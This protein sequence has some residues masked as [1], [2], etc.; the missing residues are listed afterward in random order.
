M[1]QKE[2]E[3][4]EEEKEKE[5]GLRYTKRYIGERGESAKWW[6]YFG[7]LFQRGLAVD[8]R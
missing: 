7:I 8:N 3:E 2:N 5:R 4:K 1:G 6:M